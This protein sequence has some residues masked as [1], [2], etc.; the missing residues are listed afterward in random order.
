MIAFTCFEMFQPCHRVNFQSL[1]NRNHFL[2][3]SSMK[4]VLLA[5]LKKKTVS[6]CRLDVI[7]KC[8]SRRTVE[9]IIS[10]LVSFSSIYR[11]ILLACI[12]E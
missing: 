10:A 4:I 7:D 8:F 12:P 1:S 3:T 9:E 6:I 5:A 11:K 2:V